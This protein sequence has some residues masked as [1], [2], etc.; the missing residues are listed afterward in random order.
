MPEEPKPRKKD[1]LEKLAEEF[2]RKNAEREARQLQRLANEAIPPIDQSDPG[3]PW[4]EAQMFLDSTKPAARAMWDRALTVEGPALIKRLEPQ[5]R[6]MWEQAK[7]Q[8][9]ARRRK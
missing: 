3:F 6:A 2:L 7:A 8:A 9:K 4:A 5:A 1:S